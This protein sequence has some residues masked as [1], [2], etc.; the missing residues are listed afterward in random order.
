MNI[1]PDFLFPPTMKPKNILLFL[2]LGLVILAFAVFRSKQ[3]VEVS[4]ARIKTENE[5]AKTYPPLGGAEFPVPPLVPANLLTNPPPSPVLT[6][7]ELEALAMK[8]DADSLLV[9]LAELTN[10]DP[11]IRAAARKATVQFGDRAA[12][13]ELRAVAAR[14]ED[15][16]EKRALLE[17]ADFLEL[18]PLEIRAGTNAGTR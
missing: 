18:P 12:A 14:T 13:P 15:V 1:A 7:D 10:P 6:V 9:I 11:E 5:A 16:D 8:H 3:P 4:P 2:L 17:A